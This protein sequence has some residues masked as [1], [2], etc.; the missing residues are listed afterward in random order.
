MA[1]GSGVWIERTVQGLFPWH[2]PDFLW[3]G[4]LW[5]VLLLLLCY[6]RSVPRRTCHLYFADLSIFCLFQKAEGP[7]ETCENWVTEIYT[8][9]PDQ[10]QC[11]QESKYISNTQWKCYVIYMIQVMLDFSR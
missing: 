1:C 3:D 5:D 4:R 9:H 2:G 7:H 8:H 11:H 10:S 6:S